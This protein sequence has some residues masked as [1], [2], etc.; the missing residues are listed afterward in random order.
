MAVI[1]PPPDVKGKTGA[2][3]AFVPLPV[4]ALVPTPVPEKFMAAALS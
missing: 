2:R 1:R 4:L 3:A